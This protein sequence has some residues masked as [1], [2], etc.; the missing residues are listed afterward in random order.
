[1]VVTRMASKLPWHFRTLSFLLSK[2]EVTVSSPLRCVLGGHLATCMPVLYG[3][4]QS[5][6]VACLFRSTLSQCLRVEYKYDRDDV[7][8][9]HAAAAGHGIL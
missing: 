4:H 8:D 5:F 3:V 9:D 2:L 1:M 7:D 6:P